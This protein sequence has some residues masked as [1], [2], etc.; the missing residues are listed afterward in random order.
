MERKPAKED[1]KFWDEKHS[2]EEIIAKYCAPKEKLTE[3]KRVSKG[4]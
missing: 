1:L 2:V 4:D 3:P